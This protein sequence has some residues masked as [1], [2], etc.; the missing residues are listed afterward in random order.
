[1]EKG[2]STDSSRRWPSCSQQRLNR[3]DLNRDNPAWSRLSA[4]RRCR[5]GLSLSQTYKAVNRGVG[6]QVKQK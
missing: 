6:V 1:M 3:V 4:D 5:D 2:W